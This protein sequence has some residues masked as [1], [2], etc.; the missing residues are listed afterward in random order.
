MATSGH[1]LTTRPAGRLTAGSAPRIT[2]FAL[3]LSVILAACD[4]KAAL[5][6]NADA[7]TAVATRRLVACTLMPK[8]EVSAIV[9]EQ[10]TTTES[11]DDGRSSG[12]SCHYTT[13]MNPAGMTLGV[14]WIDARDYSSAAEHLALQKA[15][16]GGA[17]LAGKLTSGVVPGGIAGLPSGPIEGLGDEANLNMTLLTAR[18][19]DYTVMVQ[20]IP[21]NMMALLTDSTVA[22]AFLT[23]EKDLVRKTLAKL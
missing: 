17:T 9:G 2:S 3:A 10:Y 8:E 12:T 22:T 21:T 20:I 23:K 16:I 14:N 1:N 4:T 19:G 11:D 15:S 5:V 13:P 18:K 7:R 6:K